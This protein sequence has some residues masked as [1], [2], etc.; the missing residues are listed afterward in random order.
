MSEGGSKLAPVTTSDPLK[1]NERWQHVVSDDRNRWTETGGDEEF[2]AAHAEAYDKRFIGK[3]A[4]LSRILSLVGSTDTVLEIGPGTGRYTRPLARR[5]SE[6]TALESSPSMVAMLERNLTTANCRA[7]V[8]IIEGE[9]PAAD[10]GSHDWVV[11]GWSLYRQSD[12]QTC[13]DRI[14]ATANQGFVIIDSP[15]SLPPH[16]RIAVRA[17][18]ALASP[19]PRQAYYCGLLADRGRYPSVETEPKTRER[20]ADSRAALVETL[21]DDSFDDPL[22][23]AEALD[24]WLH[25]EPDATDG[26]WCYRYTLPAA[27]ISYVD[28]APSQP[29]A[30]VRGASQAAPAEVDR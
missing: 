26:T 13:V 25:E 4:G 20:R 21:L 18:D 11:A 12:L 27:V 16:R 10:V 23:H 30:N 14:I 24:P 8:E 19:P 5:A 7:N 2:W 28:G 22:T 15:G 1:L 17:G 3:P 6:V 29:P 9:W